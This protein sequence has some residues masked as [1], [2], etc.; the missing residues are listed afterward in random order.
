MVQHARAHETLKKPFA[1]ERHH[2]ASAARPAKL[3]SRTAF[4]FTTHRASVSG[5]AGDEVLGKG[6]ASVLFA[7]QAGEEQHRAAW[8]VV[9]HEVLGLPGAVAVNGDD[10]ASGR[11]LDQTAVLFEEA[12]V[13]VVACEM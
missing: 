4:D 2:P 5:L 3:A 1:V 6:G 10:N 13:A 7:H 11:A 9:Y 12:L 8:A